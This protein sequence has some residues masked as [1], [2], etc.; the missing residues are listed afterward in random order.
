[1]MFSLLCL[2]LLWSTN[3]NFFEVQS[4]QFL[5]R[6]QEIKTSISFYK[7]TSFSNFYGSIWQPPQLV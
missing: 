6:F 5:V 7:S 1:F 4:F 3:I 2:Q